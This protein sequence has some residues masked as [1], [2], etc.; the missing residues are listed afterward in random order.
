MTPATFVSG[1]AASVTPLPGTAH[2]A[3]YLPPNSASNGAFLE[4]L[5]QLL[6]HETRDAAGEPE[7]LRLA[8]ATPRAWLR[9]G[10]EIDVRDAPTS[11]GPVSFSIAAATS[12]ATIELE[13]PERPPRF[14]SLRLR[15]PGGTRI[16]RVEVDGEVHGGVDRATGTI[17][18]SGRTGALTIDV[19]LAR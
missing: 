10:R 8:Y 2:R 7:G 16:G 5:R 14:L 1:E 17:D 19:R 15:L 3:M 12:A 9:A 11:F 6:V 18:L 13:L 4:T